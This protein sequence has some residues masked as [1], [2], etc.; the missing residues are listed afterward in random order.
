MFEL[1]KFWRKMG[2]LGTEHIE[3]FTKVFLN[4]RLLSLGVIYIALNIIY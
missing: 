1:I 2:K 3:F 4:K